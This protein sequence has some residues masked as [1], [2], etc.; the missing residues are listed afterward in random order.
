MGTNTT[1][2]PLGDDPDERRRHKKRL[3]AKVDQ[4]QYDAGGIVSMDGGQYQMSGKRRLYSDVRGLG[5]AYF[6]DK[7]DIRVET[8]DRP[9]A[10]GECNP[11]RALT[12]I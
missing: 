6:A 7:D 4:A 5:I 3:H 2:H 9:Q 8:Q 1:H 11:A 10:A 12:C